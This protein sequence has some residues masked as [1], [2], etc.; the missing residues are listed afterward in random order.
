M[1]C[2]ARCA[3]PANPAGM[4][5]MPRWSAVLGWTLRSCIQV[6][7]VV[8]N[9]LIRR[10]TLS[11]KRRKPLAVAALV[12]E[13]TDDKKLAKDERKRRQVELAA[14]KTDRAKIL[15]LA[16]KTS[17]LRSLAKSPPADWSMQRRRE[18]LDWATAV[19]QGLRGVSPWLEAR[20]EEA[21]EQLGRSLMG[22][23]SPGTNSARA[24]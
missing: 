5:C 24:D 19:S 8:W 10:C 1:T 21:T 7:R 22:T 9:Y 18:Y 6:T 13:V 15:K 12:A 2:C 23:P 20:F 4:D 14:T 11:S 17:N 16:D 3:L